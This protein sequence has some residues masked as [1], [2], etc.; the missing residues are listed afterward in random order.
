MRR[1]GTLDHDALEPR[2]TEPTAGLHAT[3]WQSRASHIGPDGV[4]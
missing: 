2:K 1:P 3:P 4:W